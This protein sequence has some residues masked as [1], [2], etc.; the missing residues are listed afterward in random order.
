M[1]DRAVIYS[2]MDSM[3][4]VMDCRDKLYDAMRDAEKALGIQS[5]LNTRLEQQLK[6]QRIN[7]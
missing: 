5:S 2:I 3:S 1:S 7:K 6:L 4:A